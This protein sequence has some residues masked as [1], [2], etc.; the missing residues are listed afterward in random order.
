MSLLLLGA[1]SAYTIN[2]LAQAGR[3]VKRA[4]PQR[5]DPTYV[6]VGHAILG[7]PASVVIGLG[8]VLTI[9]GVCAVY[10]DFIG[11]LAAAVVGHGVTSQQVQAVL[12]LPVILLALLRDFKY[13]A[14]TSIVGDIAVTAGAITVI[15]YGAVKKGITSPH[16]LPAFHADTYS[17]FFGQAVFLFAVHSVILPIS[18]ASAKPRRF[19]VVTWWTF[20]GVAVANALFGA[21]GYMAFTDKTS[22]LVLSN[23]GSSVVGKVVNMFL[24]VD[25]LFTIPIVLS[26][27][28]RIIER[29]VIPR[30]DP[31]TVLK[32]N[33][34][35]VVC[36]GLFV[37][38]A[39]A[40]PDINDL[41]TLVGG[42]VSPL[43]GFIFPPVFYLRLFWSRLPWHT[44][45]FN[46][47]IV[48]FGMFAGTLTTVQQVQ[49]MVK[50][51]SHH[52]GA[53]HNGTHNATDIGGM[54]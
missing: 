26:A 11:T 39:L 8:V 36:V 21:L 16:D 17:S 15:A 30:G 23:L 12:V 46:I 1:L 38:L 44:R 20:G 6:D 28:R 52:H 43:M 35:R 5:R 27:P 51:G 33:A 32:E 50:E 42:L 4:N 48:L 29:L 45:I 34:A 19:P 18:Q 3:M 2:Q 24:A 53:A 40:V 49:K 13:L 14:W 25:L 54:W 10:L 47:V 41:A 31:H 9:L 22:G 7:R 37:A